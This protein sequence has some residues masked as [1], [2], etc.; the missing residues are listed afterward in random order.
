MG[1]I[2]APRALHPLE[3]Q[4]WLDWSVVK[5]Q[6]S[7]K[8]TQVKLNS[9]LSQSFSNLNTDVAS[10]VYQFDSLCRALKMCSKLTDSTT[11][12]KM[13]VPW[14]MFALSISV[15]ISVNRLATE[16]NNTNLECWQLCSLYSAGLVGWV[17][18]VRPIHYATPGILHYLIVYDAVNLTE[19]QQWT[20]LPLLYNQCRLAS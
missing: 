15:S 19:V 10:A 16:I 2:L 11:V 20:L 18:P 1:S 17:R 7:I 8:S 9:I 13:S 6:I 3:G 4:F 5:I 12:H 14:L